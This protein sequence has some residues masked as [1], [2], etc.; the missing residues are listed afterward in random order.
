[1]Y[2]MD[3]ETSLPRFDP[4]IREWAVRVAAYAMKEGDA[5]DGIASVALLTGCSTA[6]LRRWLRDAERAGGIRPG[7]FIRS[8][9]PPGSDEREADPL[10]STDI[11][12]APPAIG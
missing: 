3:A 7:V 9:V 8:V 11:P 5:P 2:A 10:Q 12:F 4:E 1:M 6:T